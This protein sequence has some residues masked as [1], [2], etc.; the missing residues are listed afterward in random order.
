MGF[1][2]KVKDVAGK[3]VNLAGKAANVAKTEI[4]KAT[5]EINEQNARARAAA[6]NRENEGLSHEEIIAKDEAKAIIC[7]LK[8]E[9]GKAVDNKAAVESA[10]NAIISYGSTSAGRHVV[11]NTKTGLTVNLLNLSDRRIKYLH[12]TFSGLNRVGDIFQQ[13]MLSL[14]GP[15]EPRKKQTFFSGNFFD[16]SPSGILL[17]KVHIEYFEGDDVI[18]EG[19][20]LNKLVNKCKCE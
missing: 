9:Y 16:K 20:W 7:F 19:H 15:V 8:I 13:R 5:Q 3:T 12:L 2:D 18:M 6:I 17:D 11:A 10:T 4:A 14:E 1:F